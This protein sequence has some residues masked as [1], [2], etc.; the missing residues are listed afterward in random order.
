[1][2]ATLATWLAQD[3]WLAGAVARALGRLGTT[4]EAAAE[5]TTLLNALHALTDHTRWQLVPC[6]LLRTET[7][8]K[9]RRWSN[10]Q[11]GSA[12][13]DQKKRNRKG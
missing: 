2:I 4:K 7:E 9:T 10:L 6:K 3:V 1:M 5:A 13:I 11:V 8:R 12:F